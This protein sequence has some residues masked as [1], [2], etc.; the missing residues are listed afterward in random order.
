MALAFD[1]TSLDFQ[2]ARIKQVLFKS[3]LRS[4]LYGVREA[5][6]A[7]LARSE[8][9]LGQWLDAVV[10]PKYGA[11]SEVAQLETALQQQLDTGR[12]LLRL[13]QRGQIEAA[14]AGLEQLDAHAARIDALLHELERAVV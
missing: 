12:D 9:P 2:Q 4:V 7:L 3:R 14:R 13:Y 8:N 6:P 5:D 11:R 10:K 1:I